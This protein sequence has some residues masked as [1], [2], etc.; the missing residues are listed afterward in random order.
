MFKSIGFILVL[1]AIT[2]MM[3]GTFEAFQGA[4]TAT[5]ETVETAAQ[6]S[7]TQIELAQ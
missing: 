6:V 1:Y 2:Q 5:F 4:L 3:S 7:K